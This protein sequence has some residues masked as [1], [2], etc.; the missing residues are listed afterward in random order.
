M[1]SIDWLKVHRLEKEVAPQLQAID[2]LVE[3]NQEKVLTAFHDAAIAETHLLGSTGYGFDDRGREQLDEVFA[4]AFG[5]QQALVRPTFVSGTHALA[6]SLFALLRPGDNL[7]YA[8]GMPYDTLRPVIG[9]Q[10]ANQGSLCDYG[11]SFDY[12]DLTEQGTLQIEAILE[13]LLPVTKVVAIQRSAGYAWRRAL[14][15]AEISEAI[16]AIKSVRKDIF[17]LVDNCYGEFTELSEPSDVGADL[18]V[19]S[20]IKNPGGGLAPTGGYI[21]GTEAAVTQ[22]AYRLTAPGIGSHS[23]SYENYR[24][25]YQGLFL[26]PHVVG[27]A[28]KGN[29]FS[30]KALT[31]AG[32]TCEPSVQDTHGDIVLRVRLGRAERLIAF[33]QAIQ[34]YSPIDAHVLPEPWQM[35]GYSDEVI[36]ASGAFIS[37]SSIELSADGPLREPYIAYLQGGLTYEHVKIA[38]TQAIEEMN[39]R[40]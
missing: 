20:L 19:G 35:P 9:L 4:R 31:E 16:A 33:C 11:V 24:L 23:G 1:M 5:A 6:V 13:H 10:G 17:V 26:A 34:R 29:V 40:C 38:V 12:V 37:G 27:Q 2:E 25:F 3:R 28:L 18:T 21:V 22:A 15:I 30:A 36:M 8:T 14:T 39:R 32:Y 7:L